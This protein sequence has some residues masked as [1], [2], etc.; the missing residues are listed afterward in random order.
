MRIGAIAQRCGLPTRTLRYYERRG[1]IDQ[2]DRDAN[3]YRNYASDVVERVRF[4]Q[5]AQAAGL[6]LAEIARVIELRQEGE[7]PC[8][9][10]TT[11]LTEKLTEVDRRIADL[12]TV[13]TELRALLRRGAS[14]DPTAC[15]PE[16][17]CQIL[18]DD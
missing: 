8:S 4:V 17:I 18:A 15:S 13:K 1:L 10:V 5:R 16:S 9:H 7:Q 6:T 12:R 11:L 3:G 2:P 14:L